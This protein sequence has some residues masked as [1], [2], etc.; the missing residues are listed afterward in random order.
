MKIGPKG[1]IYRFMR[2]KNIIKNTKKYHLESQ[3][4]FLRKWDKNSWYWKR[5]LIFEHFNILQR[6][7]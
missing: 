6:T 2:D 4:E 1:S 7:I 3:R 5:L